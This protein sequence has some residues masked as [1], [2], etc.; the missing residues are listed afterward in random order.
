MSKQIKKEEVE[1]PNL[2]LISETDPNVLWR[3]AKALDLRRKSPGETSK[4]YFIGRSR[5]NQEGDQYETL[6]WRG[7]PN[8]NCYRYWNENGSYFEKL[9]DHSEYFIRANGHEGFTTKEGGG[10]ERRG[11]YGPK[12]YFNVHLLP[13]D[14]KAKKE[15]E[16]D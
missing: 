9:P 5:K 12:V 16:D 10:W 11:F 4:D 2:R 15:E 6:H 14:L 3:K 8:T 1:E 13:E 7:A